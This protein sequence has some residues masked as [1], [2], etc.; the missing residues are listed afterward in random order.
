MT[1]VTRRQ[2][3]GIARRDALVAAAVSL[4]LEGGPGALTHRSVAERAGL[5]LA[6][7]T[8][9][10][11]HLDDILAA[12]GAVLAGRWS[13]H[14]ARTARAFT[15]DVRAGHDVDAASALADAVLPEGDDAA[16]RGHYEH[17]VASGRSRPVA[18]R[19]VCD[20]PLVELLRTVDVAMAPAAVVALVDGAALRALGAGRSVR[21]EVRALLRSATSAP[22]LSS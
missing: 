3:R 5:P 16:V 1:T 11:D 14:T 4:V 21:E 10:F 7:T 20:G 15:A 6:A 19:G 9:Y 13:E 8:Y 17:L 22:A 12:A 2:H 18:D